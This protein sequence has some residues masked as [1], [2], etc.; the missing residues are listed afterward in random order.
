MYRRS[1][2]KTTGLATGAVLGSPLLKAVLSTAEPEVPLL[3]LHVHT[4]ANFTIER[5]LQL[6]ENRGV[7]LGIVEHPAPWALKND[8]DLRHHL[9]TLRKYPVYVG[10]QP[11]DFDWQ[12]SFSKSLLSEVDY[13]LQDPQI[14]SMPNGESMRIWEFDTY[15]DD[16]EAFMVRYQE[17]SLHVLNT[18]PIDIFAWPL[19]LPVCIARH[20]DRLWTVE[21]MQ[22]IIDAAKARK[23]AIEVNDMAHT[24]HEAFI[25]MAKAQ[26]LKFTL[27]SDSR[28][29]NVGRLSYCRAVIKR[30]GLIAA[31]FWVPTRKG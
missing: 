3:D 16:A 29:Q 15:V 14:F 17:H 31:D 23:I 8:A 5:A 7:K 11:V 27:G 22:A 28:N 6:A 10:L 25:L 18:A 26:G 12:K 24:P 30:C 13:I 19:F 1:F 20:Y 9:D 2:L 4:T 21:R